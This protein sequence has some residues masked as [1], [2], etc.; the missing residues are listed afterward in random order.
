MAGFEP[1]IF[2]SVGGR[3]DR[4]ATP[5]GP[6]INCFFI[7]VCAFFSN[8]VHMCLWSIVWDGGDNSCDPLAV[9]IFMY[10]LLPLQKKDVLL[11]T[12]IIYWIRDWYLGV[13]TLTKDQASAQVYTDQQFC[14]VW[15]KIP[16]YDT[17]IKASKWPIL[18]CI[19]KSKFLCKL[20]LPNLNIPTNGLNIYQMSISIPKI[21]KIYQHFPIQGHPK[22]S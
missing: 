13:Y 5:P 7:Q 18:C 4:Y 16:L 11:S 9:C 15:H 22:Y 21:Q 2:C 12:A 17:I 10:M 3:D 19:T 8:Y 1:G 6:D 14:V 20:G